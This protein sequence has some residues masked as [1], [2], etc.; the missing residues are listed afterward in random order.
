MSGRLHPDVQKFKAFVKDHP[1]VLRDVKRNEKTLQDLYEEWTLFGDD[2]P[3]W[4]TY[5][6]QQPSFSPEQAV[7]QDSA[8]E[9]Q[10]ETKSSGATAANILAMI[11]SMNMNDLQNQLSQFNGALTSLQELLGTFRKGDQ[12]QGSG[13]NSS[14]PFSFRDD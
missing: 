1:Y 9:S 2:D 13:P 3:V 7:S 14:S 10:Q 11:K 6:E 5:K 4:E 12:E 8:S